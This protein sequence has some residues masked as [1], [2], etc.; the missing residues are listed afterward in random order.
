MSDIIL[1]DIDGTVFDIEAFGRATREEFVK[2]LKTPHDDLA[3]AIADYYSELEDSTHFNARDISVFLANR[4]GVDAATLDVV[5]WEDDAIFE[6]SL[7]E[8]TIPVLERLAK[9]YTLG[10]F[11]QGFEELQSRKLKASGIE[12]YF[13]QEY[14]FLHREKTSDSVIESL[15]KNAIV[16]DDNH[17][18]VKTIARH[19]SA[20]WINRKTADQDPL[21]QTVHT[22]TE[23]AEKLAV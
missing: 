20:F 7:Y 10:A 21:L 13:S 12:K 14:M 11:S 18:V 4:Y 23:F 22:L 6:S 1:L 5:F 19:L 16:I 3:R 8:E 9:K 17:E 2:I 15:P